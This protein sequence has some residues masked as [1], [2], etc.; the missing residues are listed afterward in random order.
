M[1][2]KEIY[3]KTKRIPVMGYSI[4]LTEKLDGSNMAIFKKD[5]ELYIAQR[6]TIISLSEYKNDEVKKILY[7]GLYNWLEE[8]GEYLKEH[9][10]NNSCICGE[11]LG[12]GCLKYDVGDFPHRWYMFAKA[13]ID[14]DYNLYN[15]NYNHD[16][17]KYPFDNQEFPNFLGIV[18]I[19]ADIRNVPNKEQLDNIYSKYCEKVGNRNV[20][21]FVINNN[22]SICKYVRMK[23]GK[24]VEYS[25]T[26]H[27]GGE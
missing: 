24:L 15:L 5:D 22:N 18:P 1:F 16:L 6:K 27:K 14:E 2:K 11:W 9:L 7:K 4:Q 23:N 10:L 13:N 19:V 20:E 3:P 26:D 8:H 17:F 25:D 12:M 21:G